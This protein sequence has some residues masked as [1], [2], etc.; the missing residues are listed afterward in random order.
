[1]NVSKSFKRQ[2]IIVGQHKCLVDIPIKLAVRGDVD[3]RK[4]FIAQLVL[5]LAVVNCSFKKRFTG[6]RSGRCCAIRWLRSQVAHTLEPTVKSVQQEISILRSIC[7]GS[8]NE[9]PGTT[10]TA[11]SWIRNRVPS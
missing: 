3:D 6:C 4:L 5:K 8:T 2:F 1:M 11:K 10:A 9:R 7:L